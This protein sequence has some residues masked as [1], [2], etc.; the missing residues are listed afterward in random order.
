MQC[1]GQPALGLEVTFLYS[2]VIVKFPNRIILAFSF[3]LPQMRGRESL[4]SVW[5]AGRQAE[6]SFPNAFLLRAFL[7]PLKHV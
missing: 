2:I 1:L 4:G 6:P 7:P 3:L 5:V